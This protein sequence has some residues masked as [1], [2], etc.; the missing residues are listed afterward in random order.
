MN[1]GIADAVDLSWKLESVIRGWGGP[2]LLESYDIE[3]R[4]VARRAVRESTGNLLR[5]LSPGPRPGLLDATWEGA[6]LRYETGKRF[7]ATMLREWYKLGIDLGYVYEPSPIVIPQEEDFDAAPSRCLRP[8]DP[9]LP[10]DGYLN[11][12]TRITPSLLREWNRLSVHL[13]LASQVP[14]DWDPL[15]AREVMLYRQTARPGARA[16]HVCLADGTSTLD[17]YG[18]SFVLVDTVND[19]E[20]RAQLS[21]AARA[22][23]MPLTV[24][25]VSGI[26]LD[27]LYSSPLTLV[28]PDGHVAWRGRSVS[29][30]LA[31]EIVDR[32][33]GAA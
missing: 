17:W 23:G 16:P 29:A 19:A 7:S 15:P 9:A 21:A 28:R 6:M 8:R 3:R 18:K 20:S 12:G 1:L 31:K 32:V 5:T 10:P 2:K 13:A 25:T 4:P 30:S 11:D 24:K 14:M 27:A 26:E 22:S 33:R